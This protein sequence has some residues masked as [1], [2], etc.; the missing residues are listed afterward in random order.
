MF[1]THRS[2]RLRRK[3]RSRRRQSKL[4]IGASAR[5][6]QLAHSAAQSSLSVRHLAVIKGQGCDLNTHTHT[7]THTHAHAHAH[8]NAQTH[9]AHAQHTHAHKHAHT[10]THTLPPSPPS[11]LR[12]GKTQFKEGWWVGVQLDEPMGKNNGRCV[13]SHDEYA[14]LCAF[15][16]LR[17]GKQGGTRTNKQSH[18]ATQQMKTDRTDT[19]LTRPTSPSLL[20]LYFSCCKPRLPE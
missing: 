18:G 6:R 3:K 16:R 8:T 20:L 10:R 14:C 13:Q 4:G 15:M 1:C 11:I 7:H 9:T 19:S 5:L 12:S 2:S 17:K